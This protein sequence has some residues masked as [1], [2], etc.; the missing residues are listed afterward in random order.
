MQS[1]SAVTKAMIGWVN[2]RQQ[3]NRHRRYKSDGHSVAVVVQC[4]DKQ[5]TIENKTCWFGG[6]CLPNWSAA[7]ISLKSERLSLVDVQEKTRTIW[8]P[9][10][11]RSYNAQSQT[12]V[13]YLYRTPCPDAVHSLHYSFSV[14]TELRDVLPIAGSWHRYFGYTS[15]SC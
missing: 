5:N 1:L 9:D 2:Q 11:V 4:W 15:Q 13:S 3:T 6:V 14:Q 10:A 8:P 7:N 12:M